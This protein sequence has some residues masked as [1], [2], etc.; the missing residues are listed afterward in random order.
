MLPDVLTYAVRLLPGLLLIGTCAALMRSD[1]DPLLRIMMLVLGFMLIRDAMTPSGLWRLGAV[2]AVPWLRFTDQ[3]GILLT[4]GAGALA[5]TAL[6]LR[7]D[8]DLRVLVRWGRFGCAA[9]GLG[10]G[11]CAAV[12]PAVRRLPLT[13][14]LHGPRPD[15]VLPVEGGLLVGTSCVTG[16]CNET[17]T[18][19]IGPVIGRRTYRTPT[20]VITPRAVTPACSSSIQ[21]VPP[22]TA[23]SGPLSTRLRSAL[24]W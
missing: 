4:F 20:A 2:G 19:V 21:S 11:G 1:R 15:L 13:P 10:L 12:G 17:V 22:M 5:L 9:I 18:G 7:L 3:A 14:R 24:Q 6:V 16:R 8:R 23:T